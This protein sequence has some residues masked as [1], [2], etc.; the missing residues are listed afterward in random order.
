MLPCESL[1]LTFSN[2][3]VVSSVL[4]IYYR[5]LADGDSSEDTTGVVV[6]AE[7]M[8]LVH[9][10]IDTLPKTIVNADHALPYS[11]I[12]VFVG[13]IIACLPSLSNVLR[14][15]HLPP[16][17]TSIRSRIKSSFSRTHLPTEAKREAGTADTLPMWYGSE[18]K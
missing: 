7:L 9:P 4:S 6:Y 10:E 18:Q 11:I 15:S 8:W 1:K 17:L 2:R 14:N 3:A 5:S 13:V 12:E 16:S